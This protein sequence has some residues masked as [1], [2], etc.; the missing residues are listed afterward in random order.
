[1]NS[2][3]LDDPIIRHSPAFERRLQS[4]R[5]FQLDDPMTLLRNCASNEITQELNSSISVSQFSKIFKQELQE[6]KNLVKG[7]NEA[8]LK[9]RNDFE[10]HVSKVKEEMEK[11]GC[12][13]D[14]MDM[15]ETYLNS[16]RQIEGSKWAEI[17]TWCNKVH[18]EVNINKQNFD[19]LHLVVDAISREVKDLKPQVTET[20]NPG[21]H[22]V[23]SA[24]SETLRRRP[25]VESP[26]SVGESAIDIFHCDS[27]NAGDGQN[28]SQH[29]VER[30]LD[31]SS[32]GQHEGLSCPDKGTEEN[33]SRFAYKT[34]SSTFWQ[35]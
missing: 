22:W 20:R 11:F 28:Q 15:F 10:R 35:H 7:A 26:F 25:D 14:R 17:K 24:G 32:V 29:L 3:C 30:R 4:E 1:M 34:N 18:E 19:S 6:M 8:V 27:A 2:S 16:N 31:P 12:K 5:K 33:S 23:N 13:S 21:N 9:L